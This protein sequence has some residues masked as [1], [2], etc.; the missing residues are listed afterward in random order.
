MFPGGGLKRDVEE[1]GK[2]FKMDNR[3]RLMRLCKSKK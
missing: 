1:G 3:I 2:M